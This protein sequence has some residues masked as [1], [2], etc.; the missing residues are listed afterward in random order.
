LF[1][2]VSH[3][4][5]AKQWAEE[6]MWANYDPQQPQ[7]LNFSVGTQAAVPSFCLHQSNN[8]SNYG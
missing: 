6:L 1:Q 2:N 3:H 7:I 8:N 5:E 4:Q